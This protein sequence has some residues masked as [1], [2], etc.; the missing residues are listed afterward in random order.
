VPDERPEA[1]PPV[2][3]LWLALLSRVGTLR[4]TWVEF[5]FLLLLLALVLALGEG[6]A[7]R[8]YGRF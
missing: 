8:V 1:P 7:D 2:P 5:V 6:E 4:D 3:S